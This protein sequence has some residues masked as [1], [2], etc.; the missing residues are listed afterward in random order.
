MRAGRRVIFAAACLLP[1]FSVIASSHSA[2]QRIRF[3]DVAEAMGIRSKNV[4]GSA[5]KKYIVASTG[6]GGCF[7]DYDGDG[8]I[9]LYIVNGATFEPEPGT[10][11]PHDVLELTCLL[12]KNVP[13]PARAQIESGNSLVTVA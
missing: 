12:K 6:S 13:D 11:G 7:L 1:A 10:E 5:E 2:P 8:F 9:D 4:S 3:E